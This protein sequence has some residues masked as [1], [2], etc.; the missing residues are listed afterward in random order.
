MSIIDKLT[1]KPWLADQG[2]LEEQIGFAQPTMKIALWIFIAVI[3]VLFS[4]FISAYFIRM[5][6][7]DW[8]PLTEPGLLWF[9]TALLIVSSVALQWARVSADRGQISGLKFGL[10]AAGAATLVFLAGQYAA[11]Q[12]LSAL[13][14]FA[15]SNPANA[16]FYLLTGLHGVHILGGL[17]VWGMATNK[18]IRGGQV[19]EVRAAVELCAI[20]WHFLLLVWLGLFGLLLST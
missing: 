20:Y 3:S 12:Q 13:G 14:Y 7:T 19:D 5:E 4:L 18:L 11:W 15:A 9:N 10:L 16:F 8:R 17:I 6:L 2:A 1:V